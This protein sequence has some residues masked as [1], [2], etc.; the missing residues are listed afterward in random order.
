MLR[1]QYLPRARRCPSDGLSRPRDNAGRRLSAE[2]DSTAP[3]PQPRIWLFSS[4]LVVGLSASLDATDRFTGCVLTGLIGAGQ[5]I[6]SFATSSGEV[7]IGSRNVSARATCGR[8]YHGPVIVLFFAATRSADTSSPA[9]SVQFV[10][11]GHPDRVRHHP[12]HRSHHLRGPDVGGG[13]GRLRELPESAISAGS[14][15]ASG[16]W[17]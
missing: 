17:L 13:A 1:T 14:L 12:A 9:R 11:V 8:G 2:M 16:R 7:R 6:S 15:E 10:A 5:F 3:R 4:G